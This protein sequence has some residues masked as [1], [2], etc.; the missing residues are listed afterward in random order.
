M[1]QLW[2]NLI[3]AADRFFCIGVFPHIHRY[4]STWKR[5]MIKRTSLARR[6]YCK[7]ATYM[8]KP[9]KTDTSSGTE[10]P[11]LAAACGTDQ[12]RRRTG[13]YRCSEHPCSWV[14]SHRPYRWSGTRVWPLPPRIGQPWFCRRGPLCKWGRPLPTCKSKDVFIAKQKNETHEK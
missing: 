8:W 11:F 1:V 7:T 5:K 9:D 2:Y 4:S 12:H 6:K 10:R 13:I 3:D 14:S